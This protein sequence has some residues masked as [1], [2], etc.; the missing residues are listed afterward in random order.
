MSRLISETPHFLEVHL[1]VRCHMSDSES[2][3]QHYQIV[4]QEHFQFIL[5]LIFCRTC[6]ERL[7]FIGSNTHISTLFTGTF[8]IYLFPISQSGPTSTNSS[9]SFIPSVVSSLLYNFF[10]SVYDLEP[11]PIPTSSSRDSGMYSGLQR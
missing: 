7:K 10:L 2:N 1:R 5:L 11:P 8:D 6:F 4:S 3:F 9:C